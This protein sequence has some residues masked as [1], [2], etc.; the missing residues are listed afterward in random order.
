MLIAIS[1]SQGSGKTTLINQLIKNDANR[2]S[3]SRKTSRSILEDWG[4]TLAEI[5]ADQELTIKFQE[6][7][8]RRKIFDDS[9]IN[10]TNGQIWF[11]ERTPIDLLGY[12][13]FQLGANNDYS[14]WLDI[15]AHR[16]IYNVN[17]SNTYD[18]IFFLT[19]G[20]FSIEKD[21]VRG[22]NKY[23]SAWVD[24]GMAK[25]HS[26]YVNPNLLTVIDSLDL[27]DRVTQINNKLLKLGITPLS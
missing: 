1:G 24:A 13:T 8:L 10:R 4:V 21:G 2:Y 6:E 18:H 22:H 20:H 26:L 19:A 23:Y 5:N 3:I 12:A 9:R 17:N 25:F 27:T 7:I 15:Y 14:D 16:C 11:T